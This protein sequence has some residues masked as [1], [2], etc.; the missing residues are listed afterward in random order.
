M[1]L[2]LSAIFA[3]SLLLATLVTVWYPSILGGFRHPD[4]LG[5][6]SCFSLFVKLLKNDNMHMS[7][8]TLFY[9]AKSKVACGQNGKGSN[10]NQM[11]GA[12]GG[13][14]MGFTTA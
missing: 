11:L 14:N 13:G 10:P 9:P 12:S 1:Q 5:K 6:P 8:T 7:K 2:E 4:G 3:M